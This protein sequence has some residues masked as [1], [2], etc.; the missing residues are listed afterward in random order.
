MRSKLSTLLSPQEVQII[1]DSL[2]AIE[3][4]SPDQQYAVRTAFAEGFNRQNVVLAV[5]SAVAL[6]SSLGIWERHPR[7][8]EK[9]NH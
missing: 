1:S 9:P 4:L 7:R 6:I 3:S 2:D 8:T 5:F